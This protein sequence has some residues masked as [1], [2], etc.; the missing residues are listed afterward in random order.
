MENQEHEVTQVIQPNTNYT[1]SDETIFQLTGSEFAL[2]LNL[3]NQ[4][5]PHLQTLQM[6]MNKKL[7]G[8]I[9]AGVAKAVIVPV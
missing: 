1:W 4:F 8:A 3:I 5:M 9:I 2:L 6:V 7:E